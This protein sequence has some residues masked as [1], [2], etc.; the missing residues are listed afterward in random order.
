MPEMLSLTRAALLLGKSYN[1]AL[2]LVLIGEIRGEQQNGRWLLD[3][4][5]VARFKKSKGS[6]LT[7][8]ASK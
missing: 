5:D 1:Q 7:S 2:R 8:S 6:R 3:A 4:T